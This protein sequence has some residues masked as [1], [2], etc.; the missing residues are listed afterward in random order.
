MEYHHCGGSPADAI[1]LSLLINT[2]RCWYFVVAVVSAASCVYFVLWFDFI[3]FCF[4]QFLLK[5]VFLQT[6]N[7]FFWS[8]SNQIIKY[9]VNGSRF[10]YEKIHSILML[11]K[12]RRRWDLCNFFQ[13]SCV[14]AHK[15]TH[16]RLLIWKIVILCHCV[17]VVKWTEMKFQSVFG[18]VSAKAN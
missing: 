14:A 8:K 10:A 2:L 13:Y 12:R 6:I 17:I 1:I 7:G 11:K 16:A 5:W 9:S 4:V 15:W 18:L 3:L